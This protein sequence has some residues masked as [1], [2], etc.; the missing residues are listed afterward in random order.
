M[1]VFCLRTLA[2]MLFKGNAFLSSVLE[3]VKVSY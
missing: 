1:S 3:S 2:R